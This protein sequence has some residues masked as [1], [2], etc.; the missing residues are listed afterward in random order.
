MDGGSCHGILFRIRSVHHLA[1]DRIPDFG[2]VVAAPVLVANLVSFASSW[3][4]GGLADRIGR[5]GTCV[6][7]T[8]IGCIVAPCY[9]LTRDINWIIVGFIVQGFFAGTI[10]TLAPAYLTERFP[11]AVRSTA[12]GFC[13]HVGIGFGALVPVG[14]SYFAIEGHMGF[15]LPLLVA[16]W[17]GSAN[18]LAALVFGPETKGKVFV[19]D[20]MEEV[21]APRAFTAAEAV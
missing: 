4:W 2:A 1:S 14:V 17:F 8:G 12:A 19:P 11:T 16:T 18:L 6:I 7:V 15:A 20:L 10:V 13:Y 5:R 3:L 9:L 21:P